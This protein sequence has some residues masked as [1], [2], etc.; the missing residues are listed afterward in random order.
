MKLRYIHCCCSVTKLCPTLCNHMDSSV[1]GLPV[2]H[3]LLQFAQI[4]IQWVGDAIQASSSVSFSFFSRPQSFPASGS[5][6][7]SQFFALGS[8]SIGASASAS[9]LPMNIQGWFPLELTVLITLQSKELSRVFSSTITWNNQLVAAQPSSWSNS[10]MSTRLH[11]NHSFDSV[12]I[13]QQG[14]IPA[15]E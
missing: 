12:D 7:M 11:E 10:H 8:Q 4:H 6:T 1:P 2:L 5:F 15:F 3:H 13:C 9:V 14:D